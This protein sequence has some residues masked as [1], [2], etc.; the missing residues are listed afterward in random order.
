MTTILGYYPIAP[1]E[2]PG[3]DGKPI[4]EVTKLVII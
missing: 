4:A 2:Y 3:E 1:I